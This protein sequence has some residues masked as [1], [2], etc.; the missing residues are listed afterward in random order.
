M[1]E[2]ESESF[3][4]FEES[5][6]IMFRVWEQNFPCWMTASHNGKLQWLGKSSC[7]TF[8]VLKSCDFSGHVTVVH[9]VVRDGPKVWIPRV[10]TAENKEE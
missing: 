9:F 6:S 5:Q 7:I 1:L 2:G 3:Q 8:M 4:I 10:L